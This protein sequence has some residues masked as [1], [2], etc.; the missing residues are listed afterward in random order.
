MIT[1]KLHTALNRYLLSGD[2]NHKNKTGI[3][4][5]FLFYTVKKFSVKPFSKGLQGVGDRVPE[6]KN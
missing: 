3:K 2:K 1:L 6:K 4:P 5:V